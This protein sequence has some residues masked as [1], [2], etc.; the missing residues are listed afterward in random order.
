MGNIVILAIGGRLGLRALFEAHLPVE[1][2]IFALVCQSVLSQILV[3][4]QLNLVFL[5]GVKPIRMPVVKQRR[6]IFNLFFTYMNSILRKA[7]RRL[8]AIW[9]NS[10]KEIISVGWVWYKL[11]ILCDYELSWTWAPP[12]TEDEPPKPS[13]FAPDTCYFFL[14]TIIL[15][16]SLFVLFFILCAKCFKYFTWTFV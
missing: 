8:S 2:V 5:I 4:R 6:L 3:H 13:P 1:W 10:C 16:S 11:I 9:W 7:W 12:A 14:F 15:F